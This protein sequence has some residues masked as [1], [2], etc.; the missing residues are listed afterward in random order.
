MKQKW[1][2]IDL[3]QDETFTVLTITNSGD[4]LS[5]EPQAKIFD[6]FFTTKAMGAGMGLGLSICRT[7]S[8]E[9]QSPQFVVKFPLIAVPRIP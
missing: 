5:K 3:D 6:P 2:K 1:I 4:T 8:S 9:A 7:Y